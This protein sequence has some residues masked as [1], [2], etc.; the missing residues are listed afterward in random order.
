MANKHTLKVNLILILIVLIA[1]LVIVAVILKSRSPVDNALTRKTQT[2]SEPEPEFNT[3]PNYVCVGIA[4][5][6]ISFC[7]VYVTGPQE[8]VPKSRSPE[9]YRLFCR[10]DYYYKKAIETKVICLSPLHCLLTKHILD[11]LDSGVKKIYH[12]GYVDYS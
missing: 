2:I 8:N 6:N 12:I 3:L 10:N 11:S 1:L 7:E 5:D 4:T 9:E